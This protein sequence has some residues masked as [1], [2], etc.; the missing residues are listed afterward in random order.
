MKKSASERKSGG[1]RWKWVCTELLALAH[2]FVLF[3]ESWK[4]WIPTNMTMTTLS[5]FSSSSTAMMML[6]WLNLATNKVHALT[7]LKMKW[8]VMQ[9]YGKQSHKEQRRWRNG[10]SRRRRRRATTEL[11]N[12]K[13]NF[14][15]IFMTKE[16]RFN[17]YLSTFILVFFLLRGIVTFPQLHYLLIY[18]AGMFPL[19]DSRIFFRLNSTYTQQRNWKI[20]MWLA[21]AIRIIC[22]RVIVTHTRTLLFHS[23]WCDVGALWSSITVRWHRKCDELEIVFLFLYY[24]I[25]LFLSVEFLFSQCLWLCQKLIT[26]SELHFVHCRICRYTEL[27]NIQRIYITLLIRQSSNYFAVR[28]FKLCKVFPTSYSINLITSQTLVLPKSPLLFYSLY[29]LLS[30]LCSFFIFRYSLF[31]NFFVYFCVCARISIV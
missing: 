5:S 10:L 21:V 1:A 24:Q 17:S 7:M 26:F 2:S 12:Y 22:T 14:L 23:A 28:R 27:L 15:E 25:T 9:E 19:G 29:L 3:L 8:K 6:W 13:R 30:L 31:H 16:L 4:W 11:W 20:M 18:S